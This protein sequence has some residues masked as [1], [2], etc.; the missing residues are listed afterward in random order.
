LRV[1]CLILQVKD[2]DKLI[3]FNLAYLNKLSLPRVERLEQNLFKKLKDIETKKSEINKRVRLLRVKSVKKTASRAIVKIFSNK[4]LLDKTTEMK[5]WESRI[6]Q[7]KKEIAHS[8]LDA[9]KLKLKK[10]HVES[11]KKLNDVIFNKA[12][13]QIKKTIFKPTNKDLVVKAT[14]LLVPKKANKK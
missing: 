9:R 10:N 6:K 13:T 5:F 11:V 12:R 14:I 1:K 8:D 3:Q 7:L 2:V 4:K